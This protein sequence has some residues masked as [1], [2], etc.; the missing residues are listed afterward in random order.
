[1]NGIYIPEPGLEEQFGKIPAL[2]G[3]HLEIG[4]LPVHPQLYGFVGIQVIGIQQRI[5]NG[6]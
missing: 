5:I 6:W 4:I 2:V 3:K 1:M